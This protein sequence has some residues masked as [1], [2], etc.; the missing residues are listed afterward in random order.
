MYCLRVLVDIDSMSS[1]KYS[2]I[3]YRTGT[4]KNVSEVTIKNSI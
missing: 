4:C 3:Q 1:H 2:T